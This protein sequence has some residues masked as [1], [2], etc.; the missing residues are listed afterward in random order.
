MPESRKS[1][2]QWQAELWGDA[3]S[4]VIAWYNLFGQIAFKQASI[5]LATRNKRLSAFRA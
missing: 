5:T 1:A 2:Q 4:P 3:D